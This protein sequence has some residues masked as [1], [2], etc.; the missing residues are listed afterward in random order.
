MKNFK[1][2]LNLIICLFIYLLITSF[3]AHAQ[4]MENT[5]YQIQDSNINPFP[6]QLNTSNPNLINKYNIPS[7]VKNSESTFTFSI[8]DLDI[9]FGTLSPTN[10]I[11][12]DITIKI[13]NQ[14]KSGYKVI[15][16]EN[17]ELI[18]AKTGS[19][20]PDTTC[21]NGRCTDI[22]SDKWD[23]T[24]TYGFGYRCDSSKISCIENDNSFKELNFY[25]QFSNSSQKESPATILS[26]A[27]SIGQEA[28]ITY[29]VNISS[30]QP[31]G[32][33]SNTVT[34]IAIPNF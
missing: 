25:K 12:R 23:G 15:A 32:A 16:S 11:S 18:E 31:K 24:L 1:F 19:K 34:F 21:D 6:I 7:K 27:N 17:H 20:I 9:D 4:T 26:E 8:S 10:P 3:P 33:Y 29:K 2:K 22:V 14:I 5:M 13:K 30:S 28:N